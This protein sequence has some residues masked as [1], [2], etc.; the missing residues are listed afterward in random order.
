M[1]SVDKFYEREFKK[2]LKQ[3]KM[4]KGTETLK[5][6]DG[7]F[8]KSTLMTLYDLIKAEK[9]DTVQGIVSTGKEANVFWGYAPDET[10]VAIKIYRIAAAT[11]R[12]MWQYIVQDPRFSDIKKQYRQVVFSWAKREFKNLKRLEEYLPVPRPHIVLNNVLIMD[13]LGE[14]GIAY[15]QL[16]I[17]GPDDP[18]KDFRTVMSY[19]KGMYKE[20]IVHA[21]LSEY[22]ILVGPKKLHPIDYSQGTVMRN[23]MARQFLIRDIEN[24]KRY[25]SKF[26][27]VPDID[28]LLGQVTG[29]KNE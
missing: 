12:N 1:N 14:G 4:R 28:I 10:E 16:R 23:P 29:E 7:V 18:E 25:F 27:E 5:V 8:D 24:I 20:G 2:G 9:L 26:I 13:F 15:P 17:A 19:V 22:N 6:R 21:D 11:F 3:E